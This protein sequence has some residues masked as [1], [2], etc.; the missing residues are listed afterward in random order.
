MTNTHTENRQLFYR[1]DE[2]YVTVT[3]WSFEGQN[4]TFV[5]LVPFMKAD[6]LGPNLQIIFRTYLDIH[7][8]QYF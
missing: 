7:N 2:K 1:M 6:Q 8:R 4:V 3:Q 5:M